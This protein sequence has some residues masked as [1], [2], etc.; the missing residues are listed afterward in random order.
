MLWTSYGEISKKDQYVYKSDGTDFLKEAEPVDLKLLDVTYNVHKRDVQQTFVQPQG[1][2]RPLLSQQQSTHNISSTDI[3]ERA[4]R[5]STNALNQELVPLPINYTKVMPTNFHSRNLGE[6]GTGIFLNLTSTTSG[7]PL[8]SPIDVPVDTSAFPKQNVSLDSD[9]DD[10]DLNKIY[11]S[12]SFDKYVNENNYIVNKSDTHL[13]YNSTFT[14][15]PDVGRFMWVDFSN[16]S[17]ATTHE[18]LSMSHRRAATVKLKFEFPFYGHLIRSV[19]VATGGFIFTGDYVHSWLAATQYIAPLMANFDTS[20]SND[21]CVK[22]IDN[23]TA[24]TVQWE[25]VALQEQP[26]DG[27]FTFQATLHESGDIIF[28]YESVPNI[29]KSIDDVNHPVTI[30]LSDAYIIDH[31]EDY[32]RRKTIFEYHKVSFKQ[33]NIKN[34]TVIHF[35]PLPTC[36]GF[37][38][39]HSCVTTAIPSFKKQKKTFRFIKTERSAKTRNI[40]ASA[41]IPCQINQCSW[42][43]ATRKC[44]VGIDRHRHDW[45]SRGCDRK[46]IRDASLCQTLYTSEVDYNEVIVNDRS[47]SRSTAFAS[48]SVNVKENMGVSGVVAALLLGA[49]VLLM[50]MWIIYAY[51]NP[52]TAS[53]QI[54]IK[55]RPSQ[56]RWRRGEARYT[57]ATIHM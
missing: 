16:S 31:S 26:D 36:L 50:G 4:H 20:I 1:Q 21:S 37:T 2:P 46:Q 48:R 27:Q 38:D 51:R 33:E 41:V 56:W 12:A 8:S 43:P 44:S 35:T 54:L 57:A 52:H 11:D 25:K 17:L 6:N 39:C 13:Y 23:G 18:L 3:L 7:P 55:Y 32:V 53:G 49:L 24:F 45:L 47:I 5:K 14:T 30:G 28:A 10:L 9:T 29:I 22:Y 19:T 42:C 15:S 40:G 34:W